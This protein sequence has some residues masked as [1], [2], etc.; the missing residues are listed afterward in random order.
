M[1]LLA[2]F[3]VVLHA[4]SGLEDII[5]G[6]SVAYRHWP[7]VK[8]IVGPFTNAIT[9]R[10]TVEEMLP[11]MELLNRVRKTALEAYRNQDVPFEDVVREICLS[12]DAASVFRVVIVFQNF[13]IPERDVDGLKIELEDFDSQMSN[14]DLA[15]VFHE[16]AGTFRGALNYKTNTF[17]KNTVCQLVDLYCSVFGEIVRSPDKRICDLDA[18]SKVRIW[19]N[20][21]TRFTEGLRIA[22][23]ATFVADLLQEPIQFWITELGVPAKVEM[24]PY[25]QLFQQL[26]D[27]GSLLATNGRGINIVVIRI[28]D[29]CP[30]FRPGS[31]HVATSAAIENLKDF[32]SALKTAK[33]AAPVPFLV[34]ICPSAASNRTEEE[35][36]QE[37]ERWLILHLRDVPGIQIVTIDDVRRHYSLS[38]V[39]DDYANALGHV[40][41]SQEFFTALG[42]IISRRLH[43]LTASPFKMIV[44]DCDN[45]LWDGLCA[46]EGLGVTIGPR[47]K[48]L[49]TFL[50]NRRKEGMLV[51]L[52]SKNEENDV[53]RVFDSHPEMVLRR[54]DIISWRINWEPKS[55]NIAALAR[56]L[57]ISLDSVLFIDDN[58][59]ECAEVATHCSGVLT[60]QLPTGKNDILNFLEN[61]WV[62]DRLN[63]TAE[64]Q[65]RTNFYFQSKARDTL[66]QQLSFEEF[67]DTLDLVVE[68]RDIQPNEVARVS[69]L[70]QRTTQFNTC[71]SYRSETDINQ[72]LETGDHNCRILR[73]SDRFGDYGL[74]GAVIYKETH[75]DLHVDTFLLSCRALGRRLEQKMLLDLGSIAADRGLVWVE[76]PY[77]FSER[78]KPVLAFLEGIGLP[79][80]NYSTNGYC[81]RFPVQKLEE[82]CLRQKPDLSLPIHTSATESSPSAGWRP[83]HA[84]IR[85]I[86]TELT[87]LRA[88]HEA[89][90]LTKREEQASDAAYAVPT[91][92][93]QKSLVQMWAEILKIRRLGVHDNFFQR[94]GNSLLGTLLISRV[95]REYGVELPLHSLFEKPTVA[96]MEI[97]I[98]QEL[99]K[100][101]TPEQL[102]EAMSGLKE[103]ATGNY[104]AQTFE[105]PK[106]ST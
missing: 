101:L 61:L 21:N 20:E 1:V 25:N 12:P 5:V 24:S 43:A 39:C 91:T 28:A 59:L 60:V 57:N 32:I 70:T 52:S 26:L 86:A 56:E 69:Q 62:F 29:L 40:P 89:I 77:I 41:F 30:F 92:P 13:D 102:M 3:K 87:D 68:I 22:I 76:I 58:P 81:F 79:Y 63:V 71:R 46:E 17:E 100:Q 44:V 103:R 6:S 42:T 14:F 97:L 78:S 51:C 88:I 75:R 83:N 95:A 45:T 15:L 65:Q 31:G 64:D 48:V 11:F 106:I 82:V 85:R 16:K 35:F 72:L 74:V 90:G 9:L 37:G 10:T 55:Q 105:L 98:Q 49:Q 50:V 33:K 38:E 7:E 23:A 4:F 96:T 36:Y 93:I 73:A 104:S 27:P 2:V 34:C 94:G 53:S 8:R 19:K 84:T 47:H 54:G 66:R 18:M 99:V 67:L 80:R